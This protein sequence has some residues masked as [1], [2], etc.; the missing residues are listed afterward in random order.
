[1]ILYQAQLAFARSAAALAARC[2]E[3]AM[4][5]ILSSSCRYEVG[6]AIAIADIVVGRSIRAYLYTDAATTHR[7]WAAPEPLKFGR[8]MFP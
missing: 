4:P 2:S 8:V 3:R 5:A 7:T 6:C 1:M